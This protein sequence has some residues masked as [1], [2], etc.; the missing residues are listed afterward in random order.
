[1][2]DGIDVEEAKEE[3]W[4]WRPTPRLRWYRPA[5]GNDNDIRLEQMWERMTGECAWRPVETIL[6]D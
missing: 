3:E 6:E 1:M 2:A 5:R 4:K